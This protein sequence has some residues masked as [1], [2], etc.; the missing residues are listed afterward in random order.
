[1]KSAMTMEL[2]ACEN[3]R[4]EW[5]ILGINVTRGT[6]GWTSVVAEPTAAGAVDQPRAASVVAG[7]S[8]ARPCAS[9]CRL[10]WTDGSIDS[11]P[12]GDWFDECGTS[13]RSTDDVDFGYFNAF[14]N[15]SN[16]S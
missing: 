2:I 12:S 14:V 7:L 15:Q 8:F 6:V 4:F 10:D 1:M 5:G 16:P 11:A 9:S 13:E 3:R